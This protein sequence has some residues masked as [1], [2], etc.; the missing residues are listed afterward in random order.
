MHVCTCLCIW[1]CVYVHVFFQSDT[2]VFLFVTAYLT[3]RLFLPALRRFLYSSF[4][5]RLRQT[6]SA[7]SSFL[8][9]GCFLLPAPTYGCSMSGTQVSPSFLPTVFSFLSLPANSHHH[10]KDLVRKKN[11]SCQVPSR[12]PIFIFPLSLTYREG[13]LSTHGIAVDPVCVH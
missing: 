1:E 7:F 13:S 4:V 6:S 10:L 12:V 8:S 9:N 5:W 3:V 11:R 2:A